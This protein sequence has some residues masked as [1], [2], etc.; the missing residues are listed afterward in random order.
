MLSLIPFGPA[1]FD[2][3]ASWFSNE[4]EA[5]QWGGTGVSF[6][7][8][9]EQFSEMLTQSRADP[10]TRW[11]WMAENESDLVGHAQLSLDWRNGNARLARIAVAPAMRGRG[12]ATSLVALVVKEAFNLPEIERLELN[13]FELNTPAIRTYECLGFVQEGVRRSSARVGAERWDTVIMAL[14]R[15]D[16]KPDE[17]N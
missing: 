6:P 4:A 16:W 12:I 9:H 3:L 2:L 11:C 1:H 13:V 15:A 5:V 7:L 8:D 17:P 14:L 10:P